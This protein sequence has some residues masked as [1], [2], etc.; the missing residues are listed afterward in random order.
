MKINLMTLI[1][2]VIA[3]LVIAGLLG[4]KALS[5]ISMA[6]CAGVVYLVV[7]IVRMHRLMNRSDDQ[8]DAEGR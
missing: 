8:D 3:L 6:L 4:N 1:L 2:F 7:K 5:L